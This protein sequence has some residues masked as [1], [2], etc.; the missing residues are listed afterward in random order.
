MC[1]PE[2]RGNLY[3]NVVLAGGSTMFPGIEKRMWNELMSLTHST[4][5]RP[6]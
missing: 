5:V 4:E 1:D 2:I 6:A 3:G